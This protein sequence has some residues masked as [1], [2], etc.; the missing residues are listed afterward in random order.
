MQ[1]NHI[2]Q[3]SLTINDITNP[4]RLCIFYILDSYVKDPN[5]G[6]NTKFEAGLYQH[7]LFQSN[8]DFNLEGY[9]EDDNYADILDFSLI[10]IKKNINNERNKK[11]VELYKKNKTEFDSCIKLITDTSFKRYIN[12]C[13]EDNEPLSNEQQ[14]EIY[15]KE[16]KWNV[17]L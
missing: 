12:M 15:E 14:Q 5:I 16:F 13:I 1:N 4:K 10:N 7:G 3:F 9:L 8:D 17:K 6:P 2:Q 11:F